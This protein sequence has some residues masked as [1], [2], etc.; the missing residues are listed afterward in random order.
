MSGHVRGLAFYSFKVKILPHLSR[1][2]CDDLEATFYERA[3]YVYCLDF[4]SHRLQ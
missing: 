3:R 1:D 2:L 4:V